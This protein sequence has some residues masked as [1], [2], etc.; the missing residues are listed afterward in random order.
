M[1]APNLQSSEVSHEARLAAATSALA[2]QMRNRRVSR[3][4][5]Q[6]DVAA[7][8]AISVETYRALERCGAMRNRINPQLDTLLRIAAVLDLDAD[9]FRTIARSLPVHGSEKRP[10]AG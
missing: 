6:A 4:V 1:A 10:A 8:A 7:A 3:G 9:I 2:R 5:S